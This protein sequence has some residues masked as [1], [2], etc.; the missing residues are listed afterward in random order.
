[1]LSRLNCSLRSTL[2]SIGLGC[3]LL[4]ATL[5]SAGTLLE[6][7]E[8]KLVPAGG[9][10]D[11]RA[12]ECVSVD[13]DLAILGAPMATQRGEETGVAYLFER[14]SGQWLEAARLNGSDSVLG[15][16][17]GTAVSIDGDRA[18]VGASSAMG[19]ASVAGA[20]YVFERTQGVWVESQKIFASDGGRRR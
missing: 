18:I 11:D 8:A 17:F 4:Q 5:A 14:S 19:Q 6:E 15:D 12:G 7:E 3:L 2:G 9:G 1:M 10:V 20:V 13:R 16:Q